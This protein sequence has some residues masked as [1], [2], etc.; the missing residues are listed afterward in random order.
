MHTE[1]R[2]EAD[3]AELDLPS[4]STDTDQPPKPLENGKPKRWA[5]F[6]QAASAVIFIALNMIPARLKKGMVWYTVAHFLV[7]FSM[8]VSLACLFWGNTWR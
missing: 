3:I 4:Q 6:G 7:L 2:T 5:E 1:S 8:L